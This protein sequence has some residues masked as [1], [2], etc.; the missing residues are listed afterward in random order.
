VKLSGTDGTWL[1]LLPVG[2]EFPDSTSAVVECDWLV[3]ELTVT[4][5]EGAWSSRDACLTTGDAPLIGEWLRSVAA[6]SVPVT[7]PDADGD[8]TP[9]LTFL[10]PAL[11]F[12]LAPSDDDL[13]HL[14]VHQQKDRRRCPLSCLLKILGLGVLRFGVLVD[15]R[16]GRS[17][18][19]SK[20]ARP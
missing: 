3:I 10:E 5:A 2:Y 8:I 15:R 9:E 11:A 20:G 6:G 1:T 7:L 12:S 4:T 17:S 13:K 16:S 14:R 18:S 19:S